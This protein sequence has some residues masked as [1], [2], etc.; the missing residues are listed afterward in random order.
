M[1]EENVLDESVEKRDDSM[2]KTENR[3]VFSVLNDKSIDK[4][5]L[6][7]HTTMDGCSPCKNLSDAVK[8]LEEEY[9]QVIFFECNTNDSP[10]IKDFLMERGLF[11]HPSIVI[12]NGELIFWKMGASSVEDEKEYYRAVFDAIL[13]DE[14]EMNREYGIVK[15]HTEDLGKVEFRG[16]VIE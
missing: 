12:T 7:V 11:A 5:I 2:S 4:E 6:M 13:E 9:D 16:Q 14:I 1:N 8:E 15:V 3:N 10:K